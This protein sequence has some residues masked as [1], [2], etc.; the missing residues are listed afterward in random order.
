VADLTDL[1]VRELNIIA[2]RIGADPMAAAAEGTEHRWTA[3]ALGQW[4][5]AKRTDPTARDETYLD[6]TIAQLQDLMD[7]GADPAGE[8]DA[9]AD[10]TAPTPS[11]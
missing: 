1:T 6:L 8:D 5:V 10:P 11:P 4:L 9:E 7:D 3:V 2:R